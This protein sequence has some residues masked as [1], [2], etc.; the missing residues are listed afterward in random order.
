MAADPHSVC[1]ILNCLDEV[2]KEH[3]KVSVE[4]VVDAIG[5]RSYGPFL[6]VPALLEITP[7]GAIPGVPTFLAVIIT[8]VA[9]QMLFGRK[10]IW[11]PGFISHRSVSAERVEKASR[12]LRKIAAF[13]DKWFH[14][15][16]KALTHGVPVRIAAIL[17]IGL[18]ATVPPLELVPFA[19]SGPMIAVAAFGLALMVRDGLLM[20]IATAMSLAAFGIGFTMMGGKESS[21]G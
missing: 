4:N 3:S 12:K 7:V 14:G 11:I 1:E 8:L 15:R 21:G 9:L 16:L 18:C 13:L 10:H 6:L 2:A 19:S 5:S 20:L 17:I